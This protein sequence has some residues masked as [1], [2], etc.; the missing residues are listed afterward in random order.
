MGSLRTVA[1]ATGLILTLAT[2]AG[3][4]AAGQTPAAPPTPPPPSAGFQDGFFIQT[5]NGDNRLLFGLVAQTDGRF[6][7]D[8]PLPIVNTFAIRKMRPT[9]SG[10][11]ARYFD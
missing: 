8:D 4:Q 2:L 1:A 6:S 11:V 9:F 3:A 10:R 7:L 5:A